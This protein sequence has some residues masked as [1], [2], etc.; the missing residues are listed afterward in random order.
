MEELDSD[1]FNPKVKLK[2][3]EVWHSKAMEIVC[4]FLPGDCPLVTHINY[5]YQKHFN[6]KES[7]LEIEG[8]NSN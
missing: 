4:T 3:A 6:P 5:S 2:E 7:Y 8:E 1:V